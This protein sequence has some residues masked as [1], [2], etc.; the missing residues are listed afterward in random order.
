MVP[1]KK[2]LVG[3]LTATPIKL[4]GKFKDPEIEV[5]GKGGVVGGLSDAA[6]LPHIYIPAVS[7]GRLFDVVVES[8]T[9]DSPCLK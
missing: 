2:K 3:G 1:D 7:M 8:N 4:T 6:L 9:D 5:L